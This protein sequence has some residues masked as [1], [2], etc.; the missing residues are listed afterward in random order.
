MTPHWLDLLA[1][2]SSGRGRYYREGWGDE[3]LIARLADPARFEDPPPPI[4]PAW[5]TPRVEGHVVVTDAAFPAPLADLLP[6]PARRALVRRLA[7]AAQPSAPRPVYV[8]LSSSADEGWSM[9]DRVWRPLVAE[10]AVE[11]IFLESALYGARR[12]AGQDGPNLRTFAEQLLMNVSMVE[13]A[14]ALLDWLAREGHA[15]LGVGG[16]S[17]GGAMAAL[18]A[19]V[20]PRPLAAAIFAAGLSPVPIYTEGLL[21]R[22]IVFEAL[23]ERARERFQAIFGVANLDRHPLPRRLDAT[24]LVAGRRDGYVHAAQVE[25]LH[26]HWPGSELRWLDTGHA[27]GLLLGAKH[28]RRAAEDAMHRLG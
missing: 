1:A 6:P 28:L 10:G 17:M 8:V 15:R 18:V 26:R 20:T 23:G 9:R 4:A 2:W 25:A 22:G 16:F 7:P 12:P 24:I 21:S 11:A 27:G 5:G 14:R 3:P 13:E 19:A